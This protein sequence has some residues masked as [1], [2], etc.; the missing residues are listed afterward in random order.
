[1][2]KEITN[3]LRF[4]AKSSICFGRKVRE[5][6]Q[7]CKLLTLEGFEGKKRLK[8][9][10]CFNIFRTL[11]LKS[12]TISRKFFSRIA[13]TVVRPCRGT[14]WWFFHRCFLFHFWSLDDYFL[15]FWQRN[16][17]SGS[18]KQSTCLEETVVGK[19]LWKTVFFNCLDSE[20]RNLD[21]FWKKNG[22]ILK[23][24]AYVSERKNFRKNVFGELICHQFWTL[25]RKNLE[26]TAKNW[27][28][29]SKLSFVCTEKLLQSIVFERKCWKF[30][31]LRMSTEV[32]GTVVKIFV[33]GCQKWKKCPE[34]QIREN[35]SPKTKN[36]TNFLKILNKLFILLCRKKS[37]ELSKL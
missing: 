29:M 36:I 8:V 12:E 1:M 30:Q 25:T 21:F 31:V 35:P 13:T 14:F 5:V 26:K 10:A 16:Y 15:V 23:A 28:G 27:A 24:V 32:H 7:K 2:E 6:C 4:W 11:S 17:L 33:Q 9:A 18:K 22:T 3:F 19:L 37:P 20:H 34:E